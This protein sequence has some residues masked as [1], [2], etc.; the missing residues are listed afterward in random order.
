[1][2]EE[3]GLA[4]RV[5]ARLRPRS[6][7]DRALLAGVVL[8]ALVSSATGPVWGRL[9]PGLYSVALF[10]EGLKVDPWGR[11]L[12]SVPLGEFPWKRWPLTLGIRADDEGREVFVTQLYWRPFHYSLGPNGVDE[13]TLGDDI[14]IGLV[15]GRPQRAVMLGAQRDWQGNP[16]PRLLLFLLCHGGTLLLAVLLLLLYLTTRPPR[17]PSLGT[18]RRLALES[19]VVTPFLALPL[20]TYASIVA[21]EFYIR[22]DHNPNA[23]SWEGMLFERVHQ[24]LLLQDPRA[25][26][27]ILVALIWLAILAVRLTHPPEEEPP[28]PTSAE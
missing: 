12:A 20:L 4:S 15:D 18:P 28:A 23:P 9:D 1:M 10:V 13:G 16:T 11:S 14:V 7:L 19:A 27:T 8:C 3:R 26:A 17:L 6:L 24:A 21:Q 22:V 25:Q 2:I 5:L